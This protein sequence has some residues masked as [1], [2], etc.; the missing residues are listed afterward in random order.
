MWWPASF[1]LGFT[2]YY[3]FSGY[4]IQAVVLNALAVLLSLA[5]LTAITFFHSSRSAAHLILVG[6]FAALVGP[7][8]F[9][10]GIDSSAIVWLVFVPS[11]QR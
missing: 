4:P 6:F 1:E 9:T 2:I 11:L 10:G 5:G 8:V 7:G 3:Y